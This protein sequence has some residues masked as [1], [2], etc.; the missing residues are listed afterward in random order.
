MRR[1]KLAQAI[2]IFFAAVITAAALILS[3]Y[4]SIAPSI[5]RN[6]ISKSQ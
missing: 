5:E 4:S 2:A 1:V 3:N 6:N